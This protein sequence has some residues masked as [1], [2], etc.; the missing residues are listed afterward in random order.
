MDAN[1]SIA[2]T[3]EHRTL[4]NSASNLDPYFGNATTSS[5][6]FGQ[7]FNIPRIQRDAYGHIS[8][9]AN[10]SITI[11]ATMAD[12]TFGQNDQV[13]YTAGLMSGADKAKLDLFSEAEYYAEKT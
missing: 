11:P 9:I 12:Y 2:Y 5:L 3:V 13:T 1:G 6:N 4:T 7:S 8:Y 10:Q